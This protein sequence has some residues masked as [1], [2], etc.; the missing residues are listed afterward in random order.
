MLS[1]GAPEEI[2]T[3]DP[4]IRSLVLYPAELRVRFEGRNLLGRL[5]KGKNNPC[6]P[7]TLSPHAP[8]SLQVPVE[9]CRFPPQAA[10]WSLSPPALLVKTGGQTARAIV[11]GGWGAKLDFSAA[12]GPGSR[13][14][15]RRA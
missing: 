13:A 11:A 15:Q 2:R 1:V 9:T 4:Q 14:G 10:S 5:P 8:K 6:Q 3:P 7:G 12:R